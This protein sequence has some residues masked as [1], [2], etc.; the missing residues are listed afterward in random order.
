[1]TLSRPITA[2]EPA[3]SFGALR[4]PI[5]F[6]IFTFHPCG[7]GAAD[8]SQ[9]VPLTRPWERTKAGMRVLFHVGSS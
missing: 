4:G 2:A 8:P 1:M 5:L 7:N 3:V 6:A 9:A